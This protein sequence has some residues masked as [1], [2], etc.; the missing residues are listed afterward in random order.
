MLGEDDDHD[1]DHDD[2]DHHCAYD[3]TTPNTMQPCR[4]RVGYLGQMEHVCCT[5]ANTVRSRHPISHSRV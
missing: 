4:W 3:P 1:H 2:H 5:R